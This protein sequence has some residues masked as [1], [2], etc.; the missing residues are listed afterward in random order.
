[1]S[2]FYAP[3]NFDYFLE[4][5]FFQKGFKYLCNVKTT[6]KKINIMQSVEILE[7]WG[8]RLVHT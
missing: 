2:T 1:M 8:R 5:F 7:R 6:V 4:L 3:K